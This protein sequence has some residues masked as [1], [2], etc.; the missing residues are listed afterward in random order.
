LGFCAFGGERRIAE[1]DFEMK[2]TGR[3]VPVTATLEFSQEEDCED[4][5]KIQNVSRKGTQTGG[6]I[7][8]SQDEEVAAANPVRLQ[9]NYRNTRTKPDGGKALD[10]R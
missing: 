2:A 7:E 9:L 8:S 10:H 5:L 1:G 4:Q 3:S 6:L